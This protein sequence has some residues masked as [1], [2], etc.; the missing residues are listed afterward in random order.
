MMIL[1]KWLQ[2]MSWK[3]SGKHY[4]LSNTCT[5]YQFEFSFCIEEDITT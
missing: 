3:R 4:D 1:L 2:D 5:H